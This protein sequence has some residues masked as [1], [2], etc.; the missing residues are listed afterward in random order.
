MFLNDNLVMGLKL[1]YRDSSVKI[2]DGAIKK[3]FVDFLGQKDFRY[4]SLLE[5]L[6]QIIKKI[7][8]DKY[9]SNQ[10]RLLNSLLQVLILQ[11]NIVEKDLVFREFEKVCRIHGDQYKYQ[12]ANSDRYV[13][14]EFMNQLVEECYDPEWKMVLSLYS[15]FPA[16]RGQDYFNTKIVKLDPET[17]FVDQF[18]EFGDN[19]LDISSHTLVLGNYK[20]SNS[21]GI[22]VI[23]LPQVIKDRINEYL[24]GRC[25]GYLML[26]GKRLSDVSSQ[27]SGLI[28]SIFKMVKK[29]ITVDDLRKIYISEML[30]YLQN[31][32]FT[33]SQQKMYRK[34]ISE[35]QAHTLETQEF[36]YSGHKY[37]D[38]RKKSSESYMNLLLAILDDT[39]VRL[40]KDS[41]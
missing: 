14:L 4:E 24:D 7:K 30:Y 31:S 9:T 41:S 19:Y 6:D 33:L 8:E 20:T 35:I 11:N 18:N 3:I 13:N 1:K 16:L 23:K 22:R 12:E 10:K 39:E 40:F 27:F 34:K 37:D 25:Q 29:H 2:V 38:K 17:D 26:D 15:L 36:I 32:G 5:N 28:R 21:H